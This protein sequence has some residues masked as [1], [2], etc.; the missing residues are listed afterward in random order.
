[1]KVLR[2]WILLALVI[3]TFPRCWHLP[4]WLKYLNN[5]KIQAGFSMKLGTHSRHSCP[6]SGWQKSIFNLNLENES[7]VRHYATCDKAV[8]WNVFCNL[9]IKRTSELILLSVEVLSRFCLFFYSK[10]KSPCLGT[11]QIL[12]R[13]TLGRVA[14][15]FSS[16]SAANRMRTLP[17]LE[18]C[19]LCSLECTTMLEVEIC[20]LSW[21]RSS[22]QNLCWTRLPLC[23]PS[24]PQRPHTP[25]IAS[26]DP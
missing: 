22:V 26:T 18:Q 9:L 6:P 24:T 12:S 10:M 2:R 15:R 14:D 7:W 23:R 25:E 17:I 8:Q 20:F 4:F 1:M 19:V 11:L 5:Y 21:A 3:L 16:M 13:L